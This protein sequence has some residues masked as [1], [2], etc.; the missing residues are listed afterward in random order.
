MDLRQGPHRNAVHTVQVHPIQRVSERL[1]FHRNGGP[2]HS[3]GAAAVNT[4]AIRDPVIQNPQDVGNLQRV[5]TN[6]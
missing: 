1:V 3:C 2:V 4:L 6:T 5:N